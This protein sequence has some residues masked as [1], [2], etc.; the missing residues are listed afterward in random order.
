VAKLHNDKVAKWQSPFSV[1]VVPGLP[2]TLPLCHFVT[3]V[4]LLAAANLP[5][6]KVLVFDEKQGIIWVEE[7][8]KK[9]FEAPEIKKKTTVIVEERTVR[10]RDHVKTKPITAEEY[11]EAGE[12]FYFNEDYEEAIKYF[13]KAWADKQDP[14]DYFWIGA[15]YR[16][17]DN[18]TATSRIFNEILDRYPSSEVADDALFY[19]AVAAQKNNEDEKA[20]DLYRQVVE[21]YPNGTSYIGKFYFRDE[22]KNQLRTMKVD[23]MSRLKLLGFGDNNT[24]DLIKAFQSQNKLAVTGKPDKQTMELLIQ[25]SDANENKMRSNIEKSDTTYDRTLLYLSLMGFLLLVNILWGLR[26]L[27]VIKEES[28]RLKLLTGEF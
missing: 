1:M 27:R 23:I 4:L 12:K 20:F 17:Q 2:T 15:C 13:D 9:T 16:K 7:G 3:F 21:M 6:K 14:V 8:K 24:V 22:A 25:L 10:V 28:A 26:N 19:L 5:A 11:R 18:D